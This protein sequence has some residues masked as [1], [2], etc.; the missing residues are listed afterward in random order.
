MD[1][2]HGLLCTAL[3]AIAVGA[4]LEV[5]LEDGFQYQLGG[6][7]RHAV[8]DGRY[9]EWSL[10]AS[11]LRYHD[12]AYRRGPVLSGAQRFLQRDQLLL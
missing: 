3:R 2:A 6:G 8:S 5:R 12:P 10:P 9:S 4:V 7:L 1:G 11:R